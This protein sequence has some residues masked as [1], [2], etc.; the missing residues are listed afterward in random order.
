MRKPFF[1]VAAVAVAL[2]V[3]IGIPPAM[4][5]SDQAKIAQANA[6]IQQ[7]TGRCISDLKRADSEEEMDRIA[8]SCEQD[9]ENVVA[10]LESELGYEVEVVVSH[11]CVTNE[12]LDYT[13][14]F[15]PVHITGSGGR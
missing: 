2:A 4:A 15:D 1:I 6:Q 13:V 8:G 5:E 7:I 12:K 3:G 9:I 10:E 14:C 11:T